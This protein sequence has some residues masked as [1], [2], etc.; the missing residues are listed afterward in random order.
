MDPS[1]NI[2]CGKT[3]GNAIHKPINN[4]PSFTHYGKLKW[5]I[6][7]LNK[8]NWISEDYYQFRSL[9]GGSQDN[10]ALLVFLRHESVLE[11]RYKQHQFKMHIMS[12]V[13]TY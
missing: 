4:W 6:Q 13:V 10:F 2:F 12:F 1:E 3:L 8:I 9:F 11:R 5:R 7:L